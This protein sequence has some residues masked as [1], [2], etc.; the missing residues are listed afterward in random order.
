MAGWNLAL[1]FGLEIAAIVGISAA[2]W[3]SAQGV[4]RWVLVVGA[5]LIA[6]VLWGTFNV[7][8]DP[9]RSGEAPVEVSGWARLALEA[10]IL[11][12]GAVGLLVAVGPWPAAAFLVLTGLHYLVAG[13][14]IRWLLDPSQPPGS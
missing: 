14:R 4:L 5:P 2:A 3:Q 8:D 6:I 11:G 1:R 10:F 12:A 13:E 7:R 9:S